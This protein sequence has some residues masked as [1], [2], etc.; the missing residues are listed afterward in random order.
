MTRHSACKHNTHKQIVITGVGSVSAVGWGADSHFQK[1]LA[2]ESGLA[3][4][5]SWADEYPARVGCLVDSSFDPAE[6]MDKRESRRQGR[7]VTDKKVT[8]KS[9]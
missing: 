2:G 6:F 5:P 3:T 7:Y 9:N 4:M 1:L 8:V